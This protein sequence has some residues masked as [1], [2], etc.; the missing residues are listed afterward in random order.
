MSGLIYFGNATKQSWI[1]APLSGMKADSVGWGT[2]SQLLNG[3]AFVKR[4]RASHRRFDASWVGSYNTENEDSLQKIINFA[5]GYH[6]DGPFYFVDPFASNQNILPP[7]WAA[8]MLAEKDWPALTKQ[9][10]STF[11][12]ATV[13]NNY[14]HKYVEFETTNNFVSERKLTLIIPSG[15]KLHFGWHGPST[16]AATGVRIQPYK[17]SDGT[18][19][20]A[21]NPTKIVAGGSVRTNTQINGTAHSRVEIFLATTTAATVQVT[22]MIAQIIPETS[23][24]ASGGFIVGKGTTGLEFTQKPTIEYMS[25]AINTGQIGMAATWVEV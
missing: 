4:S 2:E 5:D 3:R 8:P 20:T 14:P 10:S 13:A 24:V 22:A 7:H 17:R 1:K 12:A 9:L 19:D 25:S 11:N 6:G 23:S 18:A 16:G 21:V 15:Y